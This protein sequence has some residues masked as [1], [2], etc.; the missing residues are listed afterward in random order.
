MSADKQLEVQAKTDNGPVHSFFMKWAADLRGQPA[1]R[2][3]REDIIAA[4]EQD[5]QMAGH[6]AKLKREVPKGSVMWITEAGTGVSHE[7]PIVNMTVRY[8]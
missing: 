4:W 3:T 7:G 5:P 6:V 2:I 8:G 1:V